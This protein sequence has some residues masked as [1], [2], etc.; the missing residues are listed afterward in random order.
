MISFTLLRFMQIARRRWTGPDGQER[1]LLDAD[2]IA[3]LCIERGTLNPEERRIIEEHVVLTL[4][5]L[6]SLPWPRNLRNV[7]EYA[8]CHHEKLDGSGYHRGLDSSSLP[9]PARIIGLA[10][11][12]EALTARDRPYKPGKPLSEVLQILGR[13]AEKQ[14]IDPN[15]FDLFVRNGLWLDYARQYLPPEQID[16]VDLSRIP[17]YTP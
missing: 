12:F 5:L 17:G 3:N 6:S 9:L 15:L 11:I 4:R 1:D 8:A 14:H 2:E 7:P 16:T 10:D 13:M